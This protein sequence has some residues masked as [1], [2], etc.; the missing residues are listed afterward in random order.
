MQVED[1][2]MQAVIPLN[3]MSTADKL[4]V[5][6]DIWDDLC[7]TPADVP[8]PAWHNDI[9]QAREE[10]IR[11]GESVFIDWDEAKDQIRKKIR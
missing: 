1:D 3:K 4:R 7:H 5:V 2:C 6:E 9:L 10:R 11:N 8:S